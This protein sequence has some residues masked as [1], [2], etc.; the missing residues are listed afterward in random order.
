MAEGKAIVCLLLS[1]KDTTLHMARILPIRRQDW[2]LPTCCPS[3]KRK[4]REIWHGEFPRPGEVGCRS[5]ETY[6]AE[7]AKEGAWG[8]TT[9]IYALAHT[10]EVPVLVVSPNFVNADGHHK[11]M[12]F[13]EEFFKKAE[14]TG[15]T[16]KAI[17]LH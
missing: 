8:S 15:Q 3:E 17:M 7:M 16:Q 14:G 13:G 1:P 9:E 4:F 11:V 10:Y 2:K 6:I 12:C 5:F